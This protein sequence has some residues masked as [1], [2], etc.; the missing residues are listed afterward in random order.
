MS[1]PPTPTGI[2]LEGL[3]APRAPRRDSLRSSRA[4]IRS[5]GLVN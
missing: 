5:Q 4:R 2:L 1:R 3:A